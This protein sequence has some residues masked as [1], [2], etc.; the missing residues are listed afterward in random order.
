MN[1]YD[2]S[3][4]DFL[5]AVGCLIWSRPGSDR[6]KIT[7]D[8]VDL[9]R[10][11]LVE[12]RKRRLRTVKHLAELVERA[13]SGVARAAFLQELCLELEDSNAYAFVARALV[14]KL[15]IECPS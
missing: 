9:N 10:P 4:G 1:P 11:G 6:G 15:E 5:V 13:K 14:D 7:V 3:P 2:E 8:L 12:A